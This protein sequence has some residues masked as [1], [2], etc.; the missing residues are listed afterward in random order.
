M[1]IS[2]DVVLHL[3]PDNECRQKI[4]VRFFIVTVP[5]HLAVID[6]G[7]FFIVFDDGVGI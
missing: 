5:E 3:A 7:L 4:V 1:N 2:L 6:I